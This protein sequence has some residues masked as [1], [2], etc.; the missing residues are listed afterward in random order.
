MKV[1]RTGSIGSLRAGIVES[2][3][4]GGPR[5]RWRLH[6]RLWPTVLV[7]VFTTATVVSGQE[8]DDDPTQL[9]LSY[10]HQQKVS[11]RV[12]VFGILGYREL[13]SSERFFGAWTQLYVRA[14][15]SYDLGSKLRLGGGFDARYTYQPESGDLVELRPWQEAKVYWPESPGWVRRFVLTH[16]VRLEERFFDS[17]VEDFE[18]RFR[19]RLQTK[20][21][22]NT[23]D[24]EQGSFY[25]FLAAEWFA[26]LSGASSELFADRGRATIGL[27][28]VSSPTWTF[29]LRYHSQRSRVT[30]GDDFRTNSHVIDFS[31]RSAVR[32]RDLIK[33]Q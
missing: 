7:L 22:L 18:W 20:M 1:E 12:R 23:Y 17:G 27:G 14:G 30:L 9:W 28:Y 31:V 19:Y 2:C 21:A 3:R 29:D 26:N 4:G 5:S 11:E 33:G 25:V 32:I 6:G 13:T 10:H 24:V 16:R 15:A 8:N